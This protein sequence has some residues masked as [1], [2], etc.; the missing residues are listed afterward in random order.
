MSTA[1]I[2]QTSAS[3]APPRP[4]VIRVAASRTAVELKL[5][6]REKGTVVFSFLLPI[7]LLGIFAVAFGG[8]S[9]FT[10]QTAGID[11]VHYFMPGMVA[12][13][14]ML[15]SFQTLAI[16]IATERDDRTLKRLR[17]TPMPPISYFLG[18][19]GMVLVA[20]AAQAALL[21]AM[22][23]V[24]FGID[25]PTEPSA[26]LTFAWVFVL[27]TAAGTALGIAYSSVPKSAKS[28]DALVVGPL[29]VLLFVSGVFFVFTDLPE[30]LQSAA[31]VFPVKWLAQGMRSALLPD[32]FAAVEVSG[33]WE[34]GLIALML[35]A[36]TVAA[37][38][39]ATRTFRWQRR[40]DG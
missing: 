35:A 18:K 26:W 20:A 36:W 31:A 27:G 7:A 19:I 17:G 11:F 15:V 25:L 21:F 2:Q 10:D 6:F 8:E 16:S 24:A 28:A 5:F 1:T 34:H 37:L 9:I 32:E 40:D 22:A 13:G 38:I 4:S 39:V 33:S 14:I 23:V 30:W 3:A 29:L 12:A